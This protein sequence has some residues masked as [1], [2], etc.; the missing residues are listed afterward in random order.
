MGTKKYRAY[1]PTQ[2][3][4]LPPSLRDWLNPDHLAYFVMDLVEQLDISTIVEAIRR[5]DPRGTRPYAPTMM[6]ALLVY[7]WCVGVRSSRAIE[8]LTYNDIAF[9]V[10]AANS[11]PTFSTLA[12]FRRTHEAAL[13]DLFRQ[14]LEIAQKAGLVSLVHVAID[15][16]KVQAAA[17]KHKAMSHER[18]ELTKERLER[19][20]ARILAEAEE[21][22]HAEDVRHGEEN[23]GNVVPTELARREMRLA[24]I[25][26]AMSDLADEAR[27]ARA[28]DLREQA[29]KHLENA[30]TGE[31]ETA[32]KRS[33]TLAGQRE[34]QAEQLEPRPDD[35]QDDEPP[36]TTPT[37]LPKNRPPRCPDGTPKPK[38][39]RNFTDP[40]SRIMES[41]GAF[42]QGYNCQAAVDEANQI[43]VA[44]GLTNMAPDNGNLFPMVARV[45]RNCGRAPAAATA[46]TGYW[47]SDVEEQCREIGVEVY[48]ATKRTKHGESPPPE[49]NDPSPPEADPKTRMRSKLDT[50]EGREIYRR[51]K[52]VVEPVFGQIKGA[53][54]LI[55]FLRRGLEVVAHDWGFDC[56]CHNV[57]KLYRAGWRPEPA[58]R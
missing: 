22:D 57:M 43:I 29:E 45:V 50:S 48:V 37:G 8:R 11:H 30:E 13:A 16:T 27:R 52:F 46:D 6:V 14:V 9:R 24:K 21:T 55:R 34:E 49:C 2:T 18:M 44:H 54:G 1:E 58:T 20:I 23:D 51:R 53:R 38:A 32:R 39:Q 25:K 33:R 40:D 12:L 26:Q 5:K 35:D 28:A 56:T 47:K 19:E 7:A 3:M 17:S 4:L 42:I 36:F 15:G 41:S 10:I 31:T